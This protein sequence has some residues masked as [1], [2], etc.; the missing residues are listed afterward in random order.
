MEQL[1]AQ[2]EEFLVLQSMFYRSTELEY[3]DEGLKLLSTMGANYEN[4][5][6]FRF[7]IHCKVCWV[8]LYK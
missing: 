5:E 4:R 1:R 8:S 2:Y 6:N 7:A 3:D